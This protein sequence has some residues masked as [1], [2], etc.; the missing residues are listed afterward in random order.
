MERVSWENM[1]VLYRL[2]FQFAAATLFLIWRNL[3]PIMIR[4]LKDARN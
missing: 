3:H 2:A 4:W 1:D